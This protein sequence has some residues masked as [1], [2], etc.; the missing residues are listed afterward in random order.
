ME[1]IAGGRIVRPREFPK[2]TNPRRRISRQELLQEH[3]IRI[4]EKPD[5]ET[6]VKL[7]ASYLKVAERDRTLKKKSVNAEEDE[8]EKGPDVSTLLR[9]F[10]SKKEK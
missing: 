4:R 8:P 7:V 1:E 9:K 3:S 2:P 6:F 5:D 10:E